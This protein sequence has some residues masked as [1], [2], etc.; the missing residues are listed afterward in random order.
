MAVLSEMITRPCREC[1]AQLSQGGAACPLCG[2]R[3]RPGGSRPE[4]P[5]VATYQASVQELRDQLRR[6]RRDAEAV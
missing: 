3:G 1:G 4:E 2:E 6:L 5:D